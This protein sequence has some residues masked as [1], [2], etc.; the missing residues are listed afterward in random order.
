MANIIKLL[1]LLKWN[2]DESHA[3]TQEKLRELSDEA[4]ECMGYK[5]TFKR[6]LL[7][8]AETLNEGKAEKDW[9]IVFPGYKLH[10]SQ[11]ENYYTG[12]IF[13]RH[14]ITT[15][16][17]SFII[18]Q[19]HGITFE[20]K[21]KLILKLIKAVGSKYFANQKNNLLETVDFDDLESIDF[22]DCDIIN[23]IKDITQ[24]TEFPTYLS[25]NLYSNLNIIEDAIKRKKLLTFTPSI[26]D[27]DGKAQPAE[28]DNYLVSP[29]RFIFY[30]GY[31]WLIGNRRLDTYV[32]QG[33]NYNQY[34]NTLDIYRID[35]LLNL[36]IAK[37]YYELRAKTNFV[38]NPS[39]EKQL[40]ILSSKVHVYKDN[41]KIKATNITDDYGFIEFEILWDCFPEPS[42]RDYSFIFDTF[43]YNYSIREDDNQKTIACVYAYEDCFIDWALT[44]IDKIKIIENSSSANRIRT[45]IKERITKGL[46]NL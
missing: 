11:S 43:G 30:K 17:L 44:N 25:E 20:H 7:S 23:N 42:I 12:P 13:Y 33:W 36:S 21:T 19:I 32:R 27:K 41:T 10:N 9:Q 40:D 16:E 5:S 6:Q 18:K 28:S 14:E 31:Y 35:K 38:T 3:L 37:N 26:I 15:E 1:Y 24:T 8:I 34:S 46:N 22:T 45:R 4:N 39:F 2:T 29:Y